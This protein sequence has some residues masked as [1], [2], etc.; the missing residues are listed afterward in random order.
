MYDCKYSFFFEIIAILMPRIESELLMFFFK[1]K[2]I[3]SQQL[4]PLQE[5]DFLFLAKEL[6]Q[7]QFNFSVVTILFSQ[8]FC[9]LRLFSQNKCRY[10]LSPN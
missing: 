3:F 5:D 9:H 4:K 7:K 10:F 8:L 6:F 1:K 2:I